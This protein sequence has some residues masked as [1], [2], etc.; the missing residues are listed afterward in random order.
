MNERDIFRAIGDVDD[1][2]IE[3]ARRPVRRTPLRIYLPTAVAACLCIVAIFA[4]TKAIPD[5]SKETANGAKSISSTDAIPYAVEDT[6]VHE[7]SEGITLDPPANDPQGYNSAAKLPVDF[8]FQIVWE[9][10]RYSSKE[11]LL[12]YANGSTLSLS[13]THEELENIWTLIGQ[14]EAAQAPGE[15]SL[16]LQYT[17]WVMTYTLELPQNDSAAQELIKLLEEAADRFR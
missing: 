7:R 6:P 8:S 12:T 5:G 3:G 2:L 16:T 17:A 9:G 11:E 4:L 15:N 1:D 13:L 10:N 14:M